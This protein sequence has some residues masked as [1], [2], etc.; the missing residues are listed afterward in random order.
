MTHSFPTRRSTDLVESVFALP[1]GG[2]SLPIYFERYA[3]VRSCSSYVAFCDN[4]VMKMVH[5]LGQK[6]EAEYQ[7][8]PKE[9]QDAVLESMASPQGLCARQRFGGHNE[10]TGYATSLRR[11]MGRSEEHTSELQSL[12]RITY[13]VFCLK[14]KK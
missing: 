1:W 4:D 2:T 14:K 11:A 3:R 9:E 12:M 13:A 8:L 10:N 7:H 5:A 6:W